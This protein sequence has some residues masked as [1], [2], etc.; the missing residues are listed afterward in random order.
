VRR[1]YIF[2]LV[3]LF[4]VSFIT[5]CS[6]GETLEQEQGDVNLPADAA[7]QEQEYDGDRISIVV[8]IFPQY[9]WV[10]QIIGE[11]NMH[12]FDLTFLLDNAIDTHSFNPSVSDMVRIKSSDIFMYVGGHSDGWVF[13]V[14]GSADVN[15][16][17]LTMNLLDV[18]DDQ[19]LLDGFCDDDCDEDHDHEF[20]EGHADEHVWLSLRFVKLI[21]GAIADLLSEVDPQ[22]AQIYMDNMEAYVEQLATLDS[23][24]QAV[25]D[26]A[27]VTTL[28]IADRFPFR[29]LLSD[30]GLTHYAAFPGC[31]AESEASFT[32]VISLAN[33]LNQFGLSYVIATETSDKSIARTVIN[34]TTTR[35]QSILVLDSIK[36]VTPNDVRNGVTFLS[37]MEG[38]LE[39]LREALMN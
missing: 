20:G 26:S 14:L 37:K 27:N 25:V 23:A 16:G 9:D 3:F 13:D 18:L 10:R 2:F 39:V 32:T 28:V 19:P 6:G 7:E 17:I 1:L 33:R 36:S 5:G 21:C 8:Q 29:Y 15:P 22:N 24:F 38:N 11:E 30:Y 12:R 34:S 35:D 31:S 4:F